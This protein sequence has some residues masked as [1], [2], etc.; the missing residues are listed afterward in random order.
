MLKCLVAGVA[1]ILALIGMG[2]DNHRSSQDSG[3]LH[4][5]YFSPDDVIWRTG[6]EWAVMLGGA[7]A[8]LMQAAHPLVADGISEH[9]GSESG[10]WGCLDQTMKAVWAVA[11]GSRRDAETE[12]AKVRDVHKRVRGTL[13][14]QLGP[15]PPGTEYSAEDPELL[16]WVH[17]TLVDT[18]LTVFPL[19]VRDL[20]LDEQQ[21]YYGE[22]KVM[23][24]IFGVPYSCQPKD[25]DDFARYMT[26]MLASEKICV[27]EPARKIA[28]DVLSP[29]LPWGLPVR[30]GPAWLGVRVITAGML[31]GRLREEYGLSWDPVRAGLVH[32]S[33]SWVKHMLM[34]YLPDFIRANSAA[35][36]AERE[37]LQP[38]AS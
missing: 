23:A 17:A 28:K 29:K 22:M 9:S 5:G 36:S 33:S 3:S 35:R 20:S 8:L 26:G 10:P 7:R 30:A 37:L 1:Y 21:R 38:V 15:F 2:K 34:P 24:K 6:R 18:T 13:K 4:T 16:M 11:F 32:A 25:I 12:G 14:E 31:P 19:Y 27:T